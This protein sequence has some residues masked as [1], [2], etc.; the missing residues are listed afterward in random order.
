[1]NEAMNEKTVKLRNIGLAAD[2]REILRNLSMTIQP[3][4]RFALMGPS[5]I[6]KTTL[7][8]VLAGL[9]QSTDGEV[10]RDKGL[11]ISMVFDQESLY[12]QKSC[13]ENIELGVPWNTTSKKERKEMSEHWGRIFDCSSFMDQKASTLSNG[14]RKRCALARAMMKQPDLL[15]LDETFHALDP[16]LRIGLM[17]VLLALQK[18]YG[19]ALVFA[20]HQESDAELLQAKVIRIE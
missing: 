4:D 6:G 12:P 13:R 2:G 5:G 11:K 19:F 14:Q 7:L 1:M 16:D 8:Y 9:R 18:K 17:T 15:L 10:I 3:G 20:T